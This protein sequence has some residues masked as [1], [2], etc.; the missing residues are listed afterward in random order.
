[1]KKIMLSV[2]S[3]EDSGLNIKTIIKS[4][5]IS[6]GLSL[7]LFVIFAAILTYTRFP[8]NAIPTIVLVVTIISII[9]AA[10]LSAKK[11]KSR[12]WLV[13]SITGLMYIFILYII[14]LIFTQR[15]VFDTHLLVIFL[16]AFIS[17]A[18]GGVIGINIKKPEKKYR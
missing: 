17:G 4:I 10:Q 15:A 5:I 8:E 12:G 18:V 16:I 3:I 13:G 7:I 1:M 14:S 9:Y 6:Y 2:S 11:A